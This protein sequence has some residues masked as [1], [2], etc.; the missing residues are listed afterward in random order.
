MAN[1]TTNFGWVMPNSADLVTDLPADF[2]V[3]GQAVDTS[4]VDLKGGT[5]GQ[6]LSKATNTDMDFTWVTTDD[7]NAIQNAIVDAKG[8]LV[9]AS[10]ADTPARLAVGANGYV[11]TADSAETTGL[12]WASPA[13]ALTKII[14]A[15]FSAVSTTG[16]TFDGVFTSAYKKYLIVISELVGSSYGAAL[17]FQT[18]VAAATQNTNAHYGICTQLSSAGATTNQLSN[19]ATQFS[20]SKLP[21]TIGNQLEIFATQ[22]GNSS[23]KPAFNAI[24]AQQYDQGHVNFGGVYDVAQI[25]D[26][27]IL[28]A[29]TG[30]ITGTVTV[31]GVQN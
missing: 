22:V 28:S 9:A 3:F 25:T 16:T 12:K 11:L 24:G 26:G 13:G 2:A 20:I 17:Y 19:P 30:T 29:S 15:S 10:A 18:R 27:F 7:A 5:A 21:T 23:V 4:L 14:T 6:I 31:F 1:P 8:D